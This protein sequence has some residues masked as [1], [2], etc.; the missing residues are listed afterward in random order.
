LQI[1]L[2]IVSHWCCLLIMRDMAGVLII[3]RYT[4][5]VEDWL[6]FHSNISILFLLTILWTQRICH[7]IECWFCFVH[8]TLFSSFCKQCH[9]L[10]LKFM[11]REPA[12]IPMM[13]PLLLKKPALSTGVIDL[14]HLTIPRWKQGVNE[15]SRVEVGAIYF[16][17]FTGSMERCIFCT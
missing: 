7:L 8:P 6:E 12:F 4:L 15:Q 16:C 3:L 1:C 9:C 14:S 2:L 17:P 13:M 10:S 11:G 5:N